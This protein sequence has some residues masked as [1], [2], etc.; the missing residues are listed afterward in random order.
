MPD[1]HLVCEVSTTAHIRTHFFC[2]FCF[3]YLFL[4]FFILFYFFFFSD[5]RNFLL[6]RRRKLHGSFVSA[7]HTNCHHGVLPKT[8]PSPRQPRPHLGRGSDMGD[9]RHR[10]HWLQQIQAQREPRHGRYPSALHLCYHRCHRPAGAHTI[11]VTLT[12]PTTPN[13][14]TPPVSSCTPF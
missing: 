10:P 8:S 5:C 6:Q 7:S 14:S 11:K 12:P 2:C 13:H 9:R 3:V 1:V 4:L